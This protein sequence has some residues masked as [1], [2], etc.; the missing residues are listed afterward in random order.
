M[1]IYRC[2]KCGHLINIDEVVNRMTNIFHQNPKIIFHPTYYNR[3]PFCGNSE[4]KDFI[5]VRGR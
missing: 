5:E 3:C 4:T 2:L 1:K